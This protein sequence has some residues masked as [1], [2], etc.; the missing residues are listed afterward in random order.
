MKEK[1]LI[2]CDNSIFADEIVGKLNE[3]GIPT[4][5]HDE[6]QDTVVGAYGPIVGIAIYVPEEQYDRAM[7][8]VKPNAEAREKATEE[9]LSAAN[10]AG[11]GN[12]RK[13]KTQAIII[14]LV[15]FLVVLAVYLYFMV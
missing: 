8:L 2:K 7:A 15:L 5:M 6:S 10:G 14:V 12:P 1:E 4:R 3:V 11:K 13:E 9:R